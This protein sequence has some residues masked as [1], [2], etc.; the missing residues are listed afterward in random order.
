[1]HYIMNNRKQVGCLGQWS[2]WLLHGR[3]SVFRPSTSTERQT[4]ERPLQVLLYP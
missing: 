1:L 3:G 2:Y 4:L